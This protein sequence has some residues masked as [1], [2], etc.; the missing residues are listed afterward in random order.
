LVDSNLLQIVVKSFFFPFIAELR[1]KIF[2]V[3]IGP[4]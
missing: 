1:A 4:N 3:C 2:S